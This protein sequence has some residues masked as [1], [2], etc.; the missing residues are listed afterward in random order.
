MPECISM[1]INTY[2]KTCDIFLF[3]LD[4]KTFYGKPTRKR[5]LYPID[6]AVSEDVEL[7]EDDDVAHPDYA[8]PHDESLPIQDD[9]RES[10][11]S[12]KKSQ[13]L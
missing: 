7:E 12:K 13:Q 5:V 6:P 8:P 9:I 10:S 3:Q 2:Y 11:T 1:K 4:S